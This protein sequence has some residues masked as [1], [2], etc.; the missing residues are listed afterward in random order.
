MKENRL[1]NQTCGSQG[2]GE[3]KIGSLELATIYLELDMTWATELNWTDKYIY[4]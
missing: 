1:R 2:G 3:G 4:T